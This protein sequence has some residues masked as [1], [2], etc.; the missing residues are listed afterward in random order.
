MNWKNADMV[1]PLGERAIELGN[2]DGGLSIPMLLKHKSGAISFGKALLNKGKVYCWYA[3]DFGD[4]TH[5]PYK[6][7][8]DPVVEWMECPTAKQVADMIRGLEESGECV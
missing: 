2:T 6:A 5:S 8:G 3:G 4:D 7:E 1:P